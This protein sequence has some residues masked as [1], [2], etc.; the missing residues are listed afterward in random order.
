LGKNKIQQRIKRVSI[1]L[2]L[3]SSFNII[4]ELIR[5]GMDAR[6]KFQLRNKNSNEPVY[7]T[8]HKYK[9]KLKTP[10]R[11]IEMVKF[12]LLLEKSLLIIIE[13][14]IFDI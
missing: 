13:I 4:I 9:V 2:F 5:N 6:N 11:N 8:L 12:S 3:C 14:R 10:S 7:I 1:F